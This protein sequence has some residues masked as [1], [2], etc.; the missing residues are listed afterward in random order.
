MAHAYFENEG[1]TL[2]PEALRHSLQYDSMLNWNF[3]LLVGKM[4]MWKGC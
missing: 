3:W 4:D 1:A 2:N